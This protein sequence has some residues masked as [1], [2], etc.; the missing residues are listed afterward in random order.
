MRQIRFFF[1]GSW[2][3]EMNLRDQFKRLFDLS[4]NIWMTVPYVYI[5]ILL[6]GM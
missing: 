4:E 6:G 1:T 2:L 3:G 5:Y